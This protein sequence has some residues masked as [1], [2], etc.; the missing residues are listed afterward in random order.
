V[1]LAD[2]NHHP[3]TLAKLISALRLV[4]WFCWLCGL[5]AAIAAGW[6]AYDRETVRTTW[7][8]LSR[9]VVLGIRLQLTLLF[10]VVGTLFFGG[11]L[12][13]AGVQQRRD[14]SSGGA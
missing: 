4:A 12:W 7:A 10:G 1:E 11:G 9:H 14:A 3:F 13:R 5:I 8:E 2:A 6:Q